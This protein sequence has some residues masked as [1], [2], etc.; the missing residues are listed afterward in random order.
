[1]RLMLRHEPA[2][3]NESDALGLGVWYLK[4]VQGGYRDAVE[5]LLRRA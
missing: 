3:D 2:D 5:Q 1:M 4:S